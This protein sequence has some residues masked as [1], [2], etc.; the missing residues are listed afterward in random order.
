MVPDEKNPRMALIEG[1]LTRYAPVG[2][3]KEKYSR[4]DSS[5]YWDAGVSP[6]VG[7]FTIASEYMVA[8]A[9]DVKA[10]QRSLPGEVPIE[11]FISGYVNSGMLTPKQAMNAMSEVYSAEGISNIFKNS[12]EL[13]Q[14]LSK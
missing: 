1:L 4:P 10:V 8:S 5:V 6:N 12:P 14:L 9:V 3:L 13:K 7:R 11:T 2:V